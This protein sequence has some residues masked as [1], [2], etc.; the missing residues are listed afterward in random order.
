MNELFAF[1]EMEKIGIRKG[2]VFYFNDRIDEK[3][4]SALEEI[5]EKFL[6]MARAEFT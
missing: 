2:I 6:L 5:L 3:I 1:E 4:I